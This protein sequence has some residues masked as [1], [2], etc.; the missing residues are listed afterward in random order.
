MMR[1]AIAAMLDVRVADIAKKKLITI[2]EGEMVASA[3]KLMADRN[4]GSVVITN[5]RIPVGI[6]TE[7][8]LVR[9]ILATGRDQKA[10][11]VS[12]IMTPNPITIEEDKTLGEA[13][14]LM[15]RKNIRRMLV[16]KGGEI[17]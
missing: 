11:K 3:T 16:T 9:K 15:S 17:T 12:E 14:D 10:T 8:D 6:V 4:V 2:D 13:I 5:Q 7:R 1:N